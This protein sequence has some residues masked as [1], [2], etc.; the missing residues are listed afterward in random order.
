M[1]INTSDVEF[2]L[3]NTRE[4]LVGEH[5]IHKM[6]IYWYTGQWMYQEDYRTIVDIDLSDEEH[7][8][9][10]LEQHSDPTQV[11]DSQ[12][13][14][15]PPFGLAHMNTME[16]WLNNRIDAGFQSMNERI[17]SGL[18]SLCMTGLLLIFRERLSRPKMI[19]TESPL[20]C[21]PYLASHTLH[22]LLTG[23]V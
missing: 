20:L 12:A 15:V 3:T 13:P 22:H 5:L 8:A 18:I 4:H 1:E 23:L 6:G 9:D 17:D 7:P 16:Q 11:E 21:K 19:L 2:Q 10:V 14:K